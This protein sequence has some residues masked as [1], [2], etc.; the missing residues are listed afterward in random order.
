MQNQ[1]GGHKSDV[2]KLLLLRLA[3]FSGIL[4]TVNTC[5][6]T[7]QADP[8]TK[9]CWYGTLPKKHVRTRLGYSQ[10][11]HVLIESNVVCQ[12]VTVSSP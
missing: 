8:R 10:C 4:V 5:L 3:I 9:Q 12:D 11:F 2:Y 7:A 6:E 1:R